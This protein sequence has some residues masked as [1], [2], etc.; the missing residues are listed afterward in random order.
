MV[1]KN[2]LIESALLFYISTKTE[3]HDLGRCLKLA[4]IN[5]VRVGGS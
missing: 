2:T 3:K 1:E 5:T 4:L